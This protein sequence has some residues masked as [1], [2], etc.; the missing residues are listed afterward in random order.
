MNFQN[1][2]TIKNIWHEKHKFKQKF[3]INLLT[4]KDVSGD[5]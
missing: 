2:Y 4:I 5:T 3:D 1:K